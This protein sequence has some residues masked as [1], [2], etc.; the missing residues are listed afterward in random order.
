MEGNTYQQ[1][2]LWITARAYQAGF[3]SQAA[4]VSPHSSLLG[5]V[6]LVGALHTQESSCAS[7]QSIYATRARPVAVSLYQV[8]KRTL[9]SQAYHRQGPGPHRFSL[10]LS[11]ASQESPLPLVTKAALP[12]QEMAHSAHKAGGMPQTLFSSSSNA[13]SGCAALQLLLLKRDSGCPAQAPDFQVPCLR[14]DNIACPP[15]D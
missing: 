7:W 1:P 8:L 15:G 2:F 12:G 3:G 6:L 13:H 9:Q 4:V 11:E 5:V 14:P 10:V